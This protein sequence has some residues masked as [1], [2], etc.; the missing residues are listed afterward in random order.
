MALGEGDYLGA[1]A[2]FR[3]AQQLKPGSPEPADGLMQVDQ[4]MRL[5]NI[6]SLEQKA[7]GQE[8][9]EQ[10]T[11]A[12]STYESILDLDGDLAFAKGRAQSQPPDGDAAQHARH[13]YRGS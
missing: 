13:A 3:M 8:Q 2:A 7:L 4:G 10:W 12:S 1:R 6:V 9:S 11:E 5:D